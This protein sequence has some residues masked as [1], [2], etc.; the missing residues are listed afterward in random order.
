MYTEEKQVI[1][2]AIVDGISVEGHSAEALTYKDVKFLNALYIH[3]KS[4]LSKETGLL[5]ENASG[6]AVVNRQ[7]NL[8]E[9]IFNLK[10]K[11]E[12]ERLNAAEQKQFRE[13]VKKVIAAKKEEAFKGQSLEQ[14]EALLNGG[15]VADVDTPVEG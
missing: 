9:A 5:D 3:L 6:E 15:P 4:K 2:A 8:V 10:K 12:T 11:Q 13:R 14:L 7:I 1:G